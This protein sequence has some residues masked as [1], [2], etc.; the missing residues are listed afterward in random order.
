MSGSNASTSQ[1]AKEIGLT[2]T[3]PKL[4]FIDRAVEAQRGRNEKP[5]TL[6]AFTMAISNIRYD[7]I[8][9]S[10]GVEGIL[11]E[12]PGRGIYRFTYDQVNFFPPEVNHE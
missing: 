4:A 11:V 8:V 7:V 1:T 3:D 5:P 6:F 9:H 2:T 12:I 10:V